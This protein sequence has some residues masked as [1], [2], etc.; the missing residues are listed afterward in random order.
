MM[1]AQEQDVVRRI[2]PELASELCDLIRDVPVGTSFEVSPSADICTSLELFI[3]GLL[4]FGSA[5]W[6]IAQAKNR[7]RELRSQDRGGTRARS[8]FSDHSLG[9]HTRPPLQHTHRTPAAL[10]P[11]SISIGPGS[12][13]DASASNCAGPRARFAN[14]TLVGV[15]IIQ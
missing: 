6:S 14:T 15:A 1:G 11:R 7:W 10:P 2:E 13:P 4:R 12:S 9:P 5:S 8:A 3:P